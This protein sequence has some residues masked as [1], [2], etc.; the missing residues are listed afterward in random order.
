MWSRAS[1]TAGSIR[2][3]E[4]RLHFSVL[5]GVA[6]A[7]L[8]RFAAGLVVGYFALVL[9]HELGHALFAR[10]AGARVTVLE[11][12]PLAGVCRYSG[13]LTALRRSVIAWGGIVV[14]LV[15]FTAAVVLLGRFGFP[16]PGF[17]DGL[18]WALVLENAFIIF[19]N[20][21]PVDP[22]DGDR[23][24]KLF[25]QL[26]ARRRLRQLHKLEQ[27]S[28]DRELHSDEMPDEI[29]ATVAAMMSNAAREAKNRST[30][31]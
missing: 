30:L 5:V 24:W 3:V 13:Q 22:L 11:L 4:I 8:G 27:R 20:L 29:K 17:F 31:R 28:G 12:S 14:Q 16:G 18:A 2:G 15:L 10:L 23:A 26:L 1:F 25:P 21:L 7:C 19:I 6:I 9:L